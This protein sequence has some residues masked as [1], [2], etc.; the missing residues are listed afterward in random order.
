MYL[1]KNSGCL[2]EKIKYFNM[3]KVLTILELI[4]NDD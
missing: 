3:K 1:D 2:R 4:S